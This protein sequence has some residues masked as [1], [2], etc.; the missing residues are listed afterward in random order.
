[1]PSIQFSLKS[2]IRSLATSGAIWVLLQQVLLRAL[3]AV[4]FLLIARIL[5]PAAV[6][7]IGIALLV[8]AIAEAVSDTGVWQAIVQKGAPPSNTELGATWT[9]LIFRGLCIGVVLMALAPLLSSEFHVPGSMPLLLGIAVVPVIRGFASPCWSIWMRE[10]Q[11]FR[12]AMLECC[13]ALL[14]F[15]L[16]L[17]GALL[18]WGVYAVL[19]AMVCAELCRTI[20]LFFLSGRG[21]RPNLQLGTIRHYTVYSRWIWAD[22][23]ANGLL[24]NQFD[25]IVVGKWF[26]PTSLGVYQMTSKL[27]QMLLFDLIYAFAQF[28]FPSFSAQFR[29]SHEEAFETF[30]RYLVFFVLGLG[31]IFV[32]AQIGA[33]MT[34]SVLLGSSWASVTPLFRI[35]MVS[36]AFRGLGTVLTAYLRATNRPRAVTQSLV[37][38]ICVLIV[39]V[40]MG[41]YGWG[42]SGVVAGLIPGAFA[43]T[44]WML[45][46]CLRPYKASQT[47][48]PGSGL[49]PMHHGV[50]GDPAD[51]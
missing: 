32:V 19:G 27:A 4:K 34:I 41:G 36:T 37:M 28:L 23:V 44:A 16:A 45:W 30:K 46:A 26:G 2:R 42:L 7:I 38:Q 35:A 17:T 6:G 48:D 8:L 3:V 14:D 47:A 49:A 10:R 43:S 5:G 29:R 40:P 11:F 22:S 21:F 39:A 9:L 18:G 12:L 33:S 20:T 1:M 25:R 31:V 24:L 50:V 15:T 51:T 13:T